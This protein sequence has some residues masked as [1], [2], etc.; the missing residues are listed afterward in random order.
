MGKPENP[1]C[2]VLRIRVKTIQLE[3]G[4]IKIIDKTDDEPCDPT[5][6][7]QLINGKRI[8]TKKVAESTKEEDEQP[9]NES[10]DP[11]VDAILREFL[12]IKSTPDEVK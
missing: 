10:A 6:I 1:K 5:K 7:R 8:E 12:G 4:R 2:T 9:E 3:D 11:E